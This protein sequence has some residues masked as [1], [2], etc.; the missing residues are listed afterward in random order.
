MGPGV[1]GTIQSILFWRLL[2]DSIVEA[3]TNMGEERALECLRVYYEEEHVERRYLQLRKEISAA[4]R[5]T[6]TFKKIRMNNRRN[7]SSLHLAVLRQFCGETF[8]VIYAREIMK[9]LESPF[10]NVS[11]A[12]INGIQLLAGIMGIYTVQRYGR[13][14]LMTAGIVLLAILNVVIGVTDMYEMPVECLIAMTVFMLPNGVGLSS[15]AWS[16]PSELVPPSQGKYSSLLNWACSALVAIVPPYVVGLVSNKSAYSIFF[17][18]AFYLVIAFF[19]NLRYV[20]R[21]DRVRRT[22]SYNNEEA[23]EERSVGKSL[24]R[25]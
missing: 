15:V 19:V 12:I 22:A 13:F 11:P 24:L 21:T 25:G 5:R 18:F 17:F 4:F 10:A 2:P 1:L 6:M 8:I 23:S 14:E 7:I 3:V 9:S 20:P 16:Y